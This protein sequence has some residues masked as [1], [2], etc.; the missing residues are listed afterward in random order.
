[1]RTY[2]R[3]GGRTVLVVATIGLAGCGGSSTPHVASLG[4]TSTS[5]A[6]TGG[7][8]SSSGSVSAQL[9]EY[10]QCMRSHGVQNFP[11]PSASGGFE[12]VPGL[13]RSSPA[14]EAAHAKCRQLLPSG[15]GSG[16]PPSAQALAQMV[17]VSQCMRRSGISDFPDPMTSVPSHPFGNG[18]TGLISDI[19]GVILV[20]PSSIDQQSQAFTKAAAECGFPLH[21]H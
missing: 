8:S 9:L 10:A 12:V 16:P 11:D 6:A 18:G 3:S 20:F 13:D 4:R 2:R 7:P 14:F 15:P 1:M 19:D 5:A 21:N 17:K